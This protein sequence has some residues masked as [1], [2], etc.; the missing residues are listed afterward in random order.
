MSALKGFVAAADVAAAAVAAA[1]VVLL[2]LRLL[3]AAGIYIYIGLYN[4]THMTG[5]Q[6]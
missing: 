2:L 6:Q 3:R 1:D 4:A 5:L